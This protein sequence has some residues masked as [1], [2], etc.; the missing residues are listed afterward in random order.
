LIEYF[1][2]KIRKI[3]KQLILLYP[4]RSKPL[5]AAF[6]A[7]RNRNYYLSIPVFFAQIEGICQEVTGIRFFKDGKKKPATAKWAEQ[8][9]ADSIYGL[10]VEPLHN[11]G[12][13]RIPQARTPKGINRH[14]VLHGTSCD[15]GEDKVNGYKTLS[16]LNYVG[17]TIHQVKTQ[18]K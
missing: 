3:E 6:K 9:K 18:F 7:H 15:Y 8:F 5:K 13:S 1:D 11:Y 17:L 2:S 12:P 16:L 10:I 14:D 4:H